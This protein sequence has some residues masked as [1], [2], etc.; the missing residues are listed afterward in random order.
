MYTFLSKNGQFLSFGVGILIVVIFLLQ[1]F[2]GEATADNS[3]LGFGFMCSLGLILVGAL[4]ASGFAVFQNLTNVK[5][6]IPAAIAFIATVFLMIKSFSFLFGDPTTEVVR[7]EVFKGLTEGELSFVSLAVN[8]GIGMAL[9][10]LAIF[11]ISLILN[12]FK[13]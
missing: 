13:G 5:G 6:L 11:I 12:F 8:V 10:T 7:E 3:G 1:M 4:A 9:L 2:G